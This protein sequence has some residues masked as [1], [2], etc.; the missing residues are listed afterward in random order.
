[1]FRDISNCKDLFKV[2]PSTS[3]YN[4]SI[5][6][7]S[8]EAI[9]TATQ[10]GTA[11]RTEGRRNTSRTG[12]ILTS[13]R[14]NQGPI[15]FPRTGVGVCVPAH[16]S[17][18]HAPAAGG[19]LWDYSREISSPDGARRTDGEAGDLGSIPKEGRVRGVCVEWTVV[20]QLMQKL[21][22]RRQRFI[23][24]P[25]EETSQEV[26]NAPRN[27]QCIRTAVVSLVFLAV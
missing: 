2:S 8:Q 24:L 9:Q 26:M 21:S 25:I 15:E 7:L 18:A 16:P 3:H 11:G 23:S 27:V 10:S 12:S 5:Q 13:F 14:F 1:M 20:H 17:T 22:F 4:A 19:A 6:P